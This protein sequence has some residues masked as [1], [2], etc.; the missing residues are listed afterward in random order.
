MPDPRGA[1]VPPPDV[2]PEGPFGTLAV[3]VQPQDATLLVDG[4]EWSAPEGDGPILIELPE[5]RHEVEV[6]KDGLATYHR[7]VE[8]RAGRTVSLNVSLSR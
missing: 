7:T 2:A 4:E 5:G 1:P 8:V 3:R 6:R